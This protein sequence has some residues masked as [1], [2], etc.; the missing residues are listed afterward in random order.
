MAAR[1]KGHDVS[2][3]QYGG[4]GCNVPP[5]LRF[6]CVLNVF[7]LYGFQTQDANPSIFEDLANMSSMWCT[8]V[9]R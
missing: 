3:I 8:N 5:K 9:I 2:D 6:L 1:R 7:F 4:K